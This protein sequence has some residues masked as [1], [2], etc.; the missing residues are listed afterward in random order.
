[1]HFGRNQEKGGMNRKP[2]YAELEQRV[3]ELETEA[4]ER[5]RREVALRESK[6]LFEKTFESQKDAIFILDADV[7]PKITDCNPAAEKMFGYTRQEMA[8]RTT[9][10]L[11]ISGAALKDFQKQLYP[12]ITKQ[13]FFHLNDF[14]MKRKDG[15]YF[16]SEHTVV[17]LNN[18]KAERTGWVSVV[19]DITGRKQIEEELRENEERYRLL[20][21]NVSDVIWIR[22]MNLRFT[23]IS[24]SVE[25]LTGYSVEE[26]IA[27][28]MAEVYTPHSIELA[29]KA[30]SEELSTEKDGQSDPFRVR[31]IEMEG[32]R[33]DGSTIWTEA[34]M[35]FLRDSDGHLAGIL[36][37]SRDITERKR[38]E[39]ALRESEAQYRHLFR[40]APAGIYEV[41]FTKRRFVAVN[42]VMCEYMGYT[43]EELLSMN[44][45]DI[46]AEESRPH[47][48]ERLRKIFSGERVPETVEYKI[49]AKGGREFWVILN[50]T[51]SYNE[52]KLRGATV[53]V[54][55]ITK[56]KLGEEALRRSEERLRAL[57]SELMKAQEKERTLIS[58]ELHDELGQSL[59]ILK[60]RVR[61]IGKNSYSKQHQIQKDCGAAVELVDQVIAKVRQISRDLNP[62]I[63]DDLGFCPALRCLTEG[64]MEEYEIPVSLDI[65]DIDAFVSKETARNLYR[66]CQEALTNILKHADATRVQIKIKKEE[67]RI[68]F[69]IEDDGK[70]FDAR[71]A[72]ARNVIERGL[73]LTVMEERAVL[74]GGTLEIT[75][76]VNGGGTK[77]QLT[78]PINSRGTR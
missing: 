27:L 18:E 73:G 64:L 47:Y 13:G 8:G 53:V 43:D 65:G 66:I 10:F 11:H 26:A 52:G 70:G 67:E 20:A 55:D 78:I 42:K 1:L 19:R 12:G 31:T 57:S 62:S 32:Y 54:H 21:D 36:G 77:I 63:L 72:R 22:D 24:P 33:R 41:D 30:F 74:I 71:A 6:E 75:S 48:F 28:T 60:H 9:E 44:P 69:F 61:S 38:S 39:E 51:F 68:S 7:P 2:S 17:P 50:M 56:R 25:R 14:M 35:R 23:Y 59:A 58:N 45:S 29:M 37:V 40:H 49:K 4:V 34:K 5:K 76:D 3:A 46:L 16:P 15:T